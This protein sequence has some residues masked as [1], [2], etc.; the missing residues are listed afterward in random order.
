M[1]GRGGD[2]TAHRHRPRP[3]HRIS[4]RGWRTA[5]RPG[6]GRQTLAALRAAPRDDIAA[7]DRRHAGAE[8]VPALAHEL[9]RLIGPLHDTFSI[10]G[11]DG[12]TARYGRPVGSTGA[13]RPLQH[14]SAPPPPGP[15]AGS[16]ASKSSNECRAYMSAMPASQSRRVVNDPLGSTGRLSYVQRAD[17]ANRRGIQC[18]ALHC[19]SSR[20]RR[21]F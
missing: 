13:A 18:R 7:A 4:G 14:Q 11:P 15:V 21:S 17:I 6:S 19:F 1:T 12:R 20:R 2:E 8:T 5:A 3:S 10:S 16:G 9:A